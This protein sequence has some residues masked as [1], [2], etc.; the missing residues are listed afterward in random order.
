[1]F[2]KFFRVVYVCMRGLIFSVVFSISN[3][4][5]WGILELSQQ[6]H[7]QFGLK[8]K[9]NKNL[10]VLVFLV[11]VLGVWGIWVSL[12]LWYGYLGFFLLC[13]YLYCKFMAFGVWFW[14][15]WVFDFSGFWFYS[16]TSFDLCMF[17]TLTAKFLFWVLGAC[18]LLSWNFFVYLFIF[19][20]MGFLFGILA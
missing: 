4:G 10:L 16:F 5:V 7:L 17:R 8:S 9:P 18:L 11:Y 14:V 2:I 1:M 20:N 13:L 15:L 3:W 19:L 6:G 12:V